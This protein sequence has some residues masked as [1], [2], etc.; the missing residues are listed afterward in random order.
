MSLSLSIA[1]VAE[2]IANRLLPW[3][4]KLYRAFSNASFYVFTKIQSVSQVDKVG[5]VIMRYAPIEVILRST[6]AS[7]SR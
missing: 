3:F 4:L 2:R 6:Y 1:V 5:S 7:L